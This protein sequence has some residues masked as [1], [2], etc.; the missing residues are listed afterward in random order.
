MWPLAYRL[1][2]EEGKPGGITVEDTLFFVR[3]LEA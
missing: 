2:P 1:T 3:A